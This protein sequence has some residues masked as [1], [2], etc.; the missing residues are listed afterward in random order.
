MA[1]FIM[2]SNRTVISRLL[3]PY[4]GRKDPKKW[5]RTF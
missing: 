2:D 4:T 5:L 1:E 3:V